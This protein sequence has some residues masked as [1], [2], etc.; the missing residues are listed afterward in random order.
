MEPLSNDPRG[1]VCSFLQCINDHTQSQRRWAIWRLYGQ[2]V[3]WCCM[4]LPVEEF[5]KASCDHHAKLRNLRKTS[6]VRP[7]T[8][9]VCSTSQFLFLILWSCSTIT[10]N[11]VTYNQARHCLWQQIKYLK[12]SKRSGGSVLM[13][14]MRNGLIWFTLTKN[15]LEWHLFMKVFKGDWKEE[16][17]KNAK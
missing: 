11:L 10:G 16:D 5:Y 13:I 9:Q 7:H 3:L 17:R 4:E 1:L 2:S 15:Y 8:H 6:Q 14:E 12:F